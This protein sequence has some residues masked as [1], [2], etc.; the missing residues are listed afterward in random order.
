MGEIRRWSISVDE[1]TEQIGNSLQAEFAP[2]VGDNRSRLV[3]MI[4]KSWHR[5]GFTMETLATALSQAQRIKLANAAQEI[6]TLN[7]LSQPEFPAHLAAPSAGL[8][9]P[10]VRVQVKV[11]ANRGRRLGN[12][13]Q[14]DAGATE[15]YKPPFINR[16]RPLYFSRSAA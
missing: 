16:I 9:K 5:L 14:A 15:S 6:T 3:Q 1:E 11:G 10:P 7:N 2:I 12:V 8:M 4:F 13:S